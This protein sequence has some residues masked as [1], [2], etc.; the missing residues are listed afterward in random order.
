VKEHMDG[1]DGEAVKERERDE[2]AGGEGVK[3][4]ETTRRA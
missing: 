2:E 4:G 1:V 3:V